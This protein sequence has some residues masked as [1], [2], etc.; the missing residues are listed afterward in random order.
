MESRTKRKRLSSGKAAS[1]TLPILI[2]VTALLFT[3]IWAVGRYAAR[4]TILEGV[5]IDEQSVGGMTRQEAVTLVQDYN[6]ERLEDFSIRFILEENEW[7]ITAQT[8]DLSLNV[9]EVVQEAIEVE[10]EGNILRRL[11]AS[12]SLK[13]PISLSTAYRYDEVRMESVLTQ[14]AQQVDQAPID[15][16]VSFLPDAQEKF[17]FTAEES[18]RRLALEPIKAMLN[19][20]M[21]SGNRRILLTLT[22]EEIKPSVIRDDFIGKTEL[23]SSFG[24]DLSFSA[25]DR[26]HNVRRAALEF[27]GLVIPS[28]RVVSFNGTT[29]ERSLENGYKNAPMIKADKSLEDAPGGGVS[30]TSSTL[31]NAVIRAGLEVVEFTRHSFPS[32]YVDKGLDTTVNLPSPVIDLKFKN[33]KET[34][35]YIRSVYENGQIAFEIYGE[36]L[37]EG[38]EIRIRTEVYETVPVA[39]P[40]VLPDETGEY[41]QYVDEEYE[42]VKPREGFKVRVYRELYQ[43]SERADSELLDDHFYRPIRGVIY[44]GVEERPNKTIQFDMYTEPAIQME[45]LD[46]LH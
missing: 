35:I 29:G 44:T 6:R 24:T 38:K 16:T 10:R 40:Q 2:V 3:G 17:L 18:G 30:Q 32:A 27:N 34:P 31:Y 37:G 4:D 23:I 11:F 13:K 5:Y 8:I 46:V 39:E 20:E 45:I 19:E 26:T 28:G 25:E 22:P 15:A 12:R 14:I 7:I 9:N 43:G 41:V 36:P 42:K 33:N 21:K 1:T